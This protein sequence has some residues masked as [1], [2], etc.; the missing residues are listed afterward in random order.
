MSGFLCIAPQFMV[1][2]KRLL[3]QSRVWLFY[4]LAGE[5]IYLLPAEDEDTAVDEDENVKF[6]Q[7]GSK[8]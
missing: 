5:G 8:K 4:L 2:A 7:I 6:W 1:S 3:R